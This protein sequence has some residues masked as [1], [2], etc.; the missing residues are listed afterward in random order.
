MNQ[1]QRNKRQ[2][3][4]Q[5]QIFLAFSLSAQIRVSLDQDARKVLAQIQQPGI[6]ARK[7]A[8]LASALYRLVKARKALVAHPP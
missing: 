4:T 1:T 6:S 8:N 2:W 5:P 7:V 3:A